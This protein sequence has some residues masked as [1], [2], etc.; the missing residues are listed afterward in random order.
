MNEKLEELESTLISEIGFFLIVLAGSILGYECA[1]WLGAL[2][3]GTILGTL[4]WPRGWMIGFGVG[5]FYSALRMAG[6]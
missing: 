2:V 4:D 6:C 1:G 5:A 3:V